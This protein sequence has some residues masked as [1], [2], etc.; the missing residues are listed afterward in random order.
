MV[1]YKRQQLLVQHNTTMSDDLI[2]ASEVAAT[3]E[4]FSRKEVVIA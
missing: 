4:L 1:M 3:C 2:K